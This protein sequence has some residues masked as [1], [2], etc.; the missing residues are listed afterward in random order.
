MK[1]RTKRGRIKNL[2]VEQGA[3]MKFL[4]ARGI[5]CFVSDGHTLERFDFNKHADPSRR[6]KKRGT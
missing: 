5:R 6:R 3:V 4:Q 1:P 2:K